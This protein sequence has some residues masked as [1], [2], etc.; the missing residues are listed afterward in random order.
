MICDSCCSYRE[1]FASASSEQLNYSISQIHESPTD[2]YFICFGLLE[3]ELP[4]IASARS[5]KRKKL[6]CHICRASQSRT[7]RSD[8]GKSFLHCLQ[9]ICLKLCIVLSF[10]RRHEVFSGSPERGA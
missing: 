1:N 7:K 4:Q 3:P 5:N 9:P 8:S 10:S 2:F 6:L